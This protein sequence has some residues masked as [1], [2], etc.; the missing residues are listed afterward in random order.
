MKKTP[1]S[2]G[3]GEKYELALIYLNGKG[4]AKD[5]DVAFRWFKIAAKRTISHSARW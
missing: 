5:S 1:V 2:S 4:V 3:N